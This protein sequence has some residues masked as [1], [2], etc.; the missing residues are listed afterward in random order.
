[1]TYNN[2]SHPCDKPTIWLGLAWLWVYM[3]NF[4]HFYLEIGVNMFKYLRYSVTILFIH[5]GGAESSKIVAERSFDHDLN[6]DGSHW[7]SLLSSSATLDIKFSLNMP[8]REKPSQK[9]Q[10]FQLS[11]SLCIKIRILSIIHVNNRL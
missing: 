4:A 8:Q 3:Y 2:P 5:A 7:I 10:N 11:K 1:M 9:C 6:S